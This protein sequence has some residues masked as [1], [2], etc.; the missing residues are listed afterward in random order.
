MNA[1]LGKLEQNS[2]IKEQETH[3]KEYKQ[4]VAQFIKQLGKK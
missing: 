1:V 2:F 3:L 4:E